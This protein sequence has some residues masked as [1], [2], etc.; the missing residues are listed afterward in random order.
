MRDPAAERFEQLFGPEFGHGKPF[1]LALLRNA[2]TA[3]GS[4][5]QN[6]PPVI[7][8]AGTNGKGSTIAFMRA[9][10]EAA[11]LTVHA[12][13]KPHLLQLHERFAVAG[14]E[15]SDGALIAAA[16]RV[17][18][19]APELSQFD[20]QVAAALLLFSESAAD[21]ALLETGMGGREDST[22]VLAKT[23][24][25]VIA[26]IGFDH[27]DALG[28]T[29]ADIARHKAGILKPGAPA[30]VARQAPE[31][32][33]VVEAEAERVG[34]P[35]F[36]Q[37][38]EWDVYEQAGRVV[39]QTTNRL[40]E[41]QRPKLRGRHQIEN[42]GLA[43]AAFHTL[44]L[45]PD[46]FDRDLE[47]ALHNAFIPARLTP[48]RGANLDKRIDDV[49][50]AVWVDAGHNPHAAAALADYIGPMRN[51]YGAVVAIIGMRTRKDVDAFLSVLGPAIDQVIAAPLKEAHVAP[52]EL[53]ERARKLGLRASAAPTLRYAMK[54]AARF[55]EPLVLIC[56]S[57]LLAAEALA[58]ENA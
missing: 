38:V 58:A 40:M 4:P 53:A 17:G 45:L 20:A 5:H 6:L 30:I 47:W 9:M 35:L 31:V 1:D 3:L 26:P 34:A 13:T 16:E 21:L 41:F 29:L 50:G 51:H 52:T 24:A 18:A 43:V 56:G 36:L 25:A 49:G 2:L 10:A 37:G 48:L 27:V 32:M 39:V 54:E 12:F 22:N 7:H 28:P 33:E 14:R 15:V 19:I 11:G 55:P 8:V 57:F 44:N 46:S 23:A 42:A